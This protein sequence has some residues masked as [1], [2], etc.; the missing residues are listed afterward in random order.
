MTLFVRDRRHCL[1]LIFLIMI[2]ICIRDPSSRAG[3]ADTLKKHGRTVA[4]IH[5]DYPPVSFW[6]KTTD[7]PSGFFV[8]IMDGVA[9]RAGLQVTYICRNG[10]SDMINAVESGEADISVLLMSEEREKKLMFSAPIDVTYLSFFVR[11]LSSVDADQ[12]P[13]GYPVGVIRGS[14]SYEQLRIRPGVRLSLYDSYQEGIFGLL[15]GE[16]AV[17]AGEE[18]MILK[19]A[20][21]AHL[22]DRIKKIGKPFV[23]RHRGI[24]VK[25]GNV[26]LM[27]VLNKALD[28]FVRSPEYQRI[29]LKWYGAPEPYWTVER[30]LT[31]SGLALFV[32]VC[33]MALWRY[34]SISRINRELVRNIKER[35]RAEEALRESE[36]RFRSIYAQSP[37]GVELYD[38]DGILAGANPACLELFGI[39]DVQAVRGFKLFED[40]NLPDE[41]RRRIRAGELT[42]YEMKFDFELVR[43][44]N[45]FETSKS[46]FMYLDCLI[47][48]W[49]VG[50]NRQNGFLVHVRDITER[51]RAEDALRRNEEMTRSVLDS[52][53][54]GFIVVDRDFRIMTANRSYCRQVSANCKSVIGKHCYE[55]SHKINR[56]CYDIGMECAVTMTFITGEPSTA[57]HKHSDA[58]GNIVYVET[59]AFP[60]KNESGDTTSVIE[61]ISNITERHLLEQERLKSQK[62]EAIGTL[63]GGIA[64]DFNNLLQGVFGYISLARLKRDDREQSLASLEEA[65]K[66]LHMTVKLTNQLLTF[67][68]GGKPVKRPI[69]LRPV[70]ENAAKFA[71]SGSRSQCRISADDLWQSEADEGQVGQVIQNVVLNA[72]QAMPEGGQ[73]EITARNVQIPGKN[74]PQGLEPGRYIEIAVKDN[75]IGIPEQYQ[76]KIFDPYF[77]TKEKGSGLGLATSYSIVKNHG[78]L[79]DVRSGVGKGTIFFIY[80][81]AGEAKKAECFEPASDSTAGRAGRILVMDDEQII[82]SV[83]GELITALGH[84]VEF[85]AHGKEAIEKYRAAR[86]S[87]SPFDAVILD[88]TIRGGMGGAEAFQELWKID[89]AVKAIV[90][91]GYSDDS[92]VSNHQTRGFKAFLKKPYNVNNLRNVLNMVLYG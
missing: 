18:A 82:R 29:Y 83:A 43:K 30:L 19:R 76:S 63:A 1:G 6:D 24:A 42:K 65:E 2:F 39:P 23:E 69:D 7:T 10:W 4:V 47:T 68:K 14:M 31:A 52:V 61:S 57:Y 13:K 67:S 33:G 12:V 11:K 44:M 84:R 70:I 17:F 49:N 35:Q 60:L 54:E 25:K 20:R 16:I 53:D 46:G 64:H 9:K 85:A 50:E 38:A 62:L 78:G 66:A 89:P 37:I 87:G 91:S 45:L 88:L 26:R 90:S 92:V 56:P 75:G 15:A 27:G 73:V 77:T 21:E 55:I 32:A 51:K 58:E 74:L 36:V 28:D 86:H 71:L 40:P 5:C 80:L 81:P 79:I 72:D 48:P 41:V 59:K 22:E 34:L 3:T 8:D